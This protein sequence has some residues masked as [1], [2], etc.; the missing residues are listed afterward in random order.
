MPLA[1]VR[2]H[3]PVAGG[4][5]LAVPGERVR[6]AATRWSGTGTPVVLLHGLASQRRFWNLVVP[7][8]AGLPVVAWDQRGHGESDAPEDGY[9]TATVVRDAATALDALGLSRAV[10]VGHS[11]GA[12]V[13]LSFAAAHPERTLAVVAVDGG[14]AS[15]SERWDLAETRQRLAPPR[16]HV[17]PAELPALLRRGPLGPW[18]SPAVEEAVLPIFGVDAD[19]L[20]RARLS[21]DHHLAVVDAL[22]AYDPAATLGAVRCPT[23]VVAAQPVAVEDDE[24]GREWIADK[25]RGIALAAGT[26]AQP[27][28]V[29]LAGAVHDV[30]LQ[31]PA[32]VSGV[33]RAAVDEV[34]GGNVR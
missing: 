29:I 28:V 8:L 22:W 32:L 19:G 9:D 18:W 26:L 20:A 34:S 1:P 24:A 4:R 10:V 23:W 30:P 13:A 16:V 2:P 6:L 21:H 12:C 5:D 27:R 33:V 31:W 3:G 11:W 17:D 7:G 25:Q 15:P 14:T